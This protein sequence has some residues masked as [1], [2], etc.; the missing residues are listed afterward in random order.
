MS[1]P[2]VSSVVALAIALIAVASLAVPFAGAATPDLALQKRHVGSFTIGATGTYRITVRNVGNTATVG[3]TTVRDT[4]PAALTYASAA[5]SGWTH[6]VVGNI[7]TV[8]RSA[9]LAPGD[10]A[11]FS[12]IVNVSGAAAPSV[13]NRAWVSGAGDTNHANDGGQDVAPIGVG[14]DLALEM[15]HTGQFV[16]GQLA[17]YLV[18]VTNIGSLPNF[19]MAEVIDTLPAGL[20]YVY[21]PEPTW[22]V[23]WDGHVVVAMRG[24][25]NPGETKSFTMI[26]SIDNPAPPFVTNI[27]TVF[28]AGDVNFANDRAV[29][30]TTIVGA[31]PD[32]ALTKRHA[33]PFEVGQTGVYTLVV[34]NVGFEPE[35]NVTTVL[36]TLP[37]GLGYIGAA[38]AGWTVSASGAIVTATHAAAIAAGD[39]AVLTLSVSVSFAAFPGLTNA[40]TV[41]SVDQGN[42]ANDR[43]ADPTTVFGGADLTIDK[44]HTVTFILGH[45]ATYRLVVTNVGIAATTGPATVVDSLPAGLTFAGATGTGWSVTTVD[46]AVQVVYMSHLSPIAPGDSAAFDLAVDVSA[47]APATVTNAATV[48]TEG[49]SNPTNDRDLDVAA[50]DANVPTLVELFAAEILA[51]GVRLSWRLSPGIPSDALAP[52]RG[53]ASDGVWMAVRGTPD[54]SAGACSMIDRDAAPGVTSWYR[55]AGDIAGAA[56]ATAPIVLEVPAA[57]TAF[58][59]RAVPNPTRGPTLITFETPRRARVRLDVVDIQGREVAGLSDVV[60]EPGVHGASANLGGLRAGLYFVRL[61][62]E[63]VERRQRIVLIH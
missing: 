3:A 41:S 29:D 42:P 30:P 6:A 55:L 57:I 17:S 46:S 20:T 24:G 8:T 27:A 54:V 45:T 39:S 32:L 58:A 10:S 33:A 36:D 50:V 4:L 1:R 14:I 37:A 13:T 43:A 51:D 21:T 35:A 62:A 44:R 31:G 61:R 38:G 48:S 59:I 28:T 9:A 47:T 63:G 23:T 15:H 60:R 22:N 49:D 52:Q 7:V 25:I 56:Y 26:V 5:D 34:R 12:L 40:A 18:S 53:A 19:G 16:A 11:A 2:A